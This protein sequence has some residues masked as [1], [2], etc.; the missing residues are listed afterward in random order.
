MSQ[1][2]A[3]FVFAVTAAFFAAFFIWPV[4]QIVRGGFVDADGNF[5]VAYLGALLRDPLYLGALGFADDYLKVTKKKS[6]G[7]SGRYKLLTS[8]NYRDVLE[9]RL[10]TEWV[11]NK[12]ITKDTKINF[13]LVAG[14]V[15]KNKEIELQQNFDSRG[16]LFWGPTQIKTKLTDL[17]TLKV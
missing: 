14:N 12:L 5:T 11:A 1:T 16:W 9:R 13:G 17:K 8:Q 7:V 3:R 4:L 15:F 2:F 6:A 10:K